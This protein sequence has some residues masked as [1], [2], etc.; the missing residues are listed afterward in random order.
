MA[1]LVVSGDSSGLV[2]LSAPA[3]SGTTVLTL[4]TTSGT[5]VVTGG[6][7]TI[8][9]ADGTVSAPSITNSGDTNT[10][11]FFP[12][13]D[14]IAFTEGGVESLRIDS[15]GNL[16]L[17]VT[18]SPWG[19]LKALQIQN[20]SF[21]G[22]SNTTYV[23]SNVYFDGSNFKYISTAASTLYTLSNSAG[24]HQWSTAASGTAGANITYTQAMTLDASGNLGIGT[25]SPA[26]RL[27]L[28]GSNVAFRGQLTINGGSGGLA[29][30]TLYNGPTTTTNLTGNLYSS[31]D[32][33][34][35][36]LNAYQATGYI[37]FETNAYT[38]RMRIDSSGNVLVGTTSNF[39]LITTNIG[40]NT[41]TSATI[42]SS[43]THT[44]TNT[45]GRPAITVASLGNGQDS[46][47]RTV[48]S[49]DNGSTFNGW[50]CGINIE[51]SSDI[52]SWMYN[53]GQSTRVFG[54]GV[55]KMRLTTG[56]G[57][58]T[59]TGSLGTI[60]DIRMKKDVVDATSKLDE[61]MQL[62]V[63]NYVLIDDPEERK[64]LGFVA[65]EIEQVFPGLVE[66]FDVRDQE[67]KELVMKQ[68]SV[69]TT[70]LIPMLI[71]AMQEQQAVITD[72]KTRIELLEGT[73]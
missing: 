59:T 68:K 61:L 40:A 22:L 71:K 60:S 72:L 30:L 14:T 50:T 65:Q 31:T 69:K 13:A 67:T 57:L 17:N 16:G 7:Q 63:V 54:S 35:V 18:P 10:G 66:E 24:Q 73:K 11:M 3:V 9:F 47:F 34:G 33:I 48:V 43:L 51:T 39:G 23:G 6:A 2:T 42:A 8:E 46:A 49:P 70:V 27:N 37:A 19:L 45:A 4:P 38:E 53:S 1:N 15:A 64:M 29:H 28:D 36:H 26:A 20:A 41:F 32:N 58:S 52:L 5:L 62:R 21:A 56:G 44:T 12:A 25:S 55:V